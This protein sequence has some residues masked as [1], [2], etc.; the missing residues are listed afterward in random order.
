MRPKNLTVQA[1]LAMLLVAAM[2]LLAGTRGIGLIQLGGYLDRMN[3]FAGNLDELHLQLEAAQERRL[4]DAANSSMHNESIKDLRIRLQAKRDEMKQVYDRERRLMYGTYTA[5]LVLVF[6]VSGGIYWLLMGL[7]IRPLQGMAKVANVVAAGDLSTQI[8]VKSADEIGEVMSALREMN[9]N[10]GTLIGKIRNISQ[11]IGA[12]TQAISSTSGDL[13]QHVEAQSAALQKT[14]S[15]MGQLAT[16]VSHNAEN[17][18]RARE[19]A[20]K[21][22][23]VAIKGGEEVG[24]AVKTMANLRGSSQKIGD[25]VSIIDGI[26]FQTNI[27]ALNAAVEAAR[28][29]EQ[30]RGFGV[31]AAEVRNLAQRSSAAAKEIA[32]LINASVND[33]RNGGDIVEKAGATMTEIVDAARAVDNI[34]ADIASASLQQRHEIEQVSGAIERIDQSS[35]QQ[36]LLVHAAQ[37]AESMQRQAERLIEAVS[38]FRLGST[39]S[40]VTPNAAIGAQRDIPKRHL[41]PSSNS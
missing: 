4:G 1:K 40:S 23:D 39:E 29:G 14:A 30:G 35:Q 10:L 32:T 21:A 28:A 36:A 13:S 11:S 9:T 37:A 34:M 19:L 3:S 17:A 27:L 24:A 7:V 18:G 8:T 33:L 15:T 31:V 20:A 5:M 41:L 22:R 16:T 2:I 6:V 25:I 12:S 38:A 26:T